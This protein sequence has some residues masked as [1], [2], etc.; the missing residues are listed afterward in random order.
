[1]T[2]STGTPDPDE[3]PQAGPGRASRP[4]WIPGKDQNPAPGA[5]RTSEPA[6]TPPPAPGGTPTPAPGAPARPGLARAAATGGIHAA[7]KAA[8]VDKLLTDNSD[9]TMSGDIKDIGEKI[10]QGAK[11]GTKL[12]GGAGSVAGA[13]AGAGSAL[14]HNRRARGIVIGLL[15]LGLIGAMLPVFLMMLVTNSS[16]AS[17]GVAIKS[18]DAA[19]ESGWAETDVNQMMEASSDTLAPWQVLAAIRWVRGGA[20]T[21]ADPAN[22][23]G[24]KLGDLNLR[25]P[26]GFLPLSE[27]DLARNDRAARALA[28]VFNADLNAARILD[29]DHDLTA[30]TLYGT[31]PSGEGLYVDNDNQASVARYESMRT[32]YLAAIDKLP[33][34]GVPERDEEI[35]TAAHQLALGDKLLSGCGVASGF[36]AASGTWVQPTIDADGK[37]GSGFGMR[38]HPILGIR[39]AHNG[40]DLGNA[41]G[42]PIF[43]A[44]AGTVSYVGHSSDAGWNIKI[45]HGNSVATRY[46]HINSRDDVLVE[47][48]DQVTVGQHIARMGNAGLSTSPHLHFE[49]HDHGT[50]VDPV[51]FY[52]SLGL[53]L[54]AAPTVTGAGDDVTATPA[55]ASASGGPG[56]L[57]SV[58]SVQWHGPTTFKAKDGTAVTFNKTMFDNAV[59]IGTTIAALTLDGEQLS[60]DDQQRLFKMAI[61]TGMQESWM[62]TAKNMNDGTDVGIFQER[63][64]VGWYADETSQEANKAKLQDVG[65]QTTNL[66][67]GHDVKVTAAGG[68]PVGYHIPGLTDQPNWRTD[69]LWEVIA[70]TQRPAAQYRRQYDRWQPVADNLLAAFQG[71]FTGSGQGCVGGDLTVV[72]ANIL[73]DLGAGTA[74]KQD[75]QTATAGAGIVSLQET[76]APRRSAVNEFAAQNGYT[77]VFSGKQSDVLLIS[78]A[79]GTVVESGRVWGHGA[80]DGNDEREILWVTV[81]MSTGARLTV[82]TTHALPSIESGG[83]PDGPERRWKASVKLFNLMADL[84]EEKAQEGMVIAAGDLNVDYA[85]DKREQFSG[86]PYSVLEHRGSGEGLV[87]QFSAGGVKEDVGTIGGK[88]NIDYVYGYLA[89]GSPLQHTGY[90]IETNTNSDHNFVFASFSTGQSLDAA[91]G[92]WG[93]IIAFATSLKGVYKYSWGG[94]G[95]DGPTNGEAGPGF[96]CSS[97]VRYVVYQ[98]TGKRLVLP[99]TSRAQADW[100]QGKGKAIRTNSIN[101][102]KAG[103]LVFYASGHGSGRI[104]HVALAIGNGQIVEEPGRGRSVQVNKLTDRMPGDLW[105]VARFDPAELVG[106]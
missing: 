12:G 57:S 33:I 50:P 52:T 93:D 43:A 49:V 1:M 44:S 84:A 2:D 27:D 25:A 75:L 46:L 4:R 106:N 53:D 39:R 96:D 20:S 92:T 61:M 72:Q 76:G 31:K 89:A 83:R 63:S 18:A 91:D 55:G 94:G 66:V 16:Q 59:T 102:V 30:G 77:A 87:S 73:H 78:N 103:D 51:K 14:V 32:A 62:G 60:A 23:Y 74:F 85:R 101:Q 81:Q 79:V 67:A 104:Y 90:R 64:K 22:P 7:A 35:F 70:D 9:G 8:G 71:L 98:G 54:A 36:G 10:A 65:Y 82:I 45:D 105:G 47:T 38:L 5:G 48:G 24:I 15:V 29:T 34:E 41:V 3:A 69:D 11:A 26:V 56:T 100:L 37:I 99:R 86:F 42:T 28:L 21:N 40:A 88:R 13:V 17:N 68:N 80:M 19:T 6:A 95:L 97:F 58:S